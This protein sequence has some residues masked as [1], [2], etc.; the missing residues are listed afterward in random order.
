MI[1]AAH[2]PN[3]F[4]WLPWFQKMNQ[5]DVFVV[6]TYCRFSKG[7]FQNRFHLHGQWFTIPTFREDDFIKDRRYVDPDKAWSRIKWNLGMIDQKYATFA[8][9]FDECIHEGVS[10]TNMAIIAK[11]CDML[12]IDVSKIRY[13]EES[14]MGRNDR[15]IDLCQK[16]GCD[17]YLA[18]NGSREYLDEEA[19]TANGIK[20]IWQEVTQAERIP[21][22]S[23][24][25]DD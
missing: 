24:I 8:E 18:G 7:G 11:L 16:Y 21:I 4:P 6:L 1:L 9:L 23:A 25:L 19:F 15:L 20:V 10:Q 22:M 5:A 14:K 2:Q 13:D 17:T 12:D 3:Y